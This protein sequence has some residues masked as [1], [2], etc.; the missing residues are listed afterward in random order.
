MP[1]VQ[2]VHNLAFQGH[3]P[4]TDLGRMGLADREVLIVPTDAEQGNA[5]GTGI[6]AADLVTTIG[7]LSSAVVVVI[8]PRVPPPIIT[9]SPETNASFMAF[10]VRRIR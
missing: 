1:V 4:L 3:F 6:L 8:T 7:V 2:T 10:Q 5:L 9:T